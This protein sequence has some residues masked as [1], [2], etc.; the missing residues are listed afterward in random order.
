MDTM[1][2]ETKLLVRIDV[3]VEDLNADNVLEI[4]RQIAF[5][6]MQELRE[7]LPHYSQIDGI[8]EHYN[9]P[10]DKKIAEY[11]EYLNCLEDEY[12]GYEFKDR[13]LEDNDE[14]NTREEKIEKLLEWLG[15]VFLDD[16]NY[17]PDMEYKS[18]I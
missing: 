18:E 6:N 8:P 5:Q 9:D 11:K 17:V 2:F 15:M 3:P 14:E 7:N 4:A 10:L 12:I 16:P 13:L 1:T